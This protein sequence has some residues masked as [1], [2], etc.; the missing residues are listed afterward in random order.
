[1]RRYDAYKI[2]RGDNLGDSEFWNK[3]FEDID[4]RIAAAED[5]LRNV[6]A[7][8]NRVESLALD[9]LN[10]VLTPL[11]AE[12]IQRL[13]SVS[14]LFEATSATPVTIGSGERVFSVPEGKRLTFVPLVYLVIFPTGDL[15]RYMAG[16]TV[17]YSQLS[18]ELVVDVMRA[19]G[20][21]ESSDWQI[22]PMAFVSDLEGL[23]NM[24]TDAANITT[25]DRGVVRADRDIVAA[26]KATVAADKAA[27]MAA[28][29]AALDYR[30]AAGDSAGAAAAS[31]LLAADHA[32]NIAP[33][34]PVGVPVP[35]D[36]A[37]T[38]K[39]NGRY[40]G[41][42]LTVANLPSDVDG[43]WY[44]VDHMV[45]LGDRDG[46]RHTQ[47]AYL[48][49]SNLYYIRHCIAEVWSSWLLV[50]SKR[51]TPAEIA[52]KTNDNFISTQN[53]WDA[54]TFVDVGNISGTYQF[55]LA[56]GS[57]FTATLVGNTTI[58]V[59]N[60]KPGQAIMLELVQDGSGGRTVSWSSK[61]KFPDNAAPL[62][63]TSA[64]GWACIY[65]GVYA[66]KWGAMMGAGWKVI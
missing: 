18:G 36:D 40:F 2:G 66:E 15:S 6:D 63:D 42:G 49:S 55:D 44:V 5:T 56:T 53:A 20:E 43:D 7:V 50:E 45:H 28:R 10:N 11:T 22:A 64:G 8:A 48:A 26:D 32:S 29:N 19:V 57:R 51:A 12:A 62:I 13:T 31:A 33:F 54:T 4:L 59:K 47:V 17:S 37:D 27:T 24:A 35:D 52:S 65:S 1:M 23:A 46:G 34:G 30:D 16:R 60:A 3:R 38:I 39:N 58:D 9:R 14:T 41:H 61:F 21:G 25:Q